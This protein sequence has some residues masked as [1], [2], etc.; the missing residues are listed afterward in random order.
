MSFFPII[1]IIFLFSC[2]FSNIS[3]LFFFSLP[4]SKPQHQQ[5][6]QQKNAQQEGFSTFMVSAFFIGC[7]GLCN[8]FFMLPVL[9]LWNYTG[10]DKFIFFILH[11]EIEIVPLISIQDACCVKSFVPLHFFNTHTLSPLHPFTIFIT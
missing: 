8:I 11:K 4:R 3:S 9:A 1:I 6:Q 2:F 7:C 10:I 5:Q